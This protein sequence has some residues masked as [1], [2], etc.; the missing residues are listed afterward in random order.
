M[1]NEL[2]GV[3]LAQAD[4]ESHEG[5]APAAAETHSEVGHEAGG[6]GGESSLPPFLRFDPGVWIWTMVVFVALLVILKKM[7]WKPIIASLEDRDKTIKASL[8]QAA[9]IQEETKRMTEEQNRILAQARHEA[10]SMLQSSKQA[11]EDLRR[12]LEQAAQDEKA[13]IIASATHEIDAS[14]RAAMAD[15]KKTT[16]DLS[17]QIAE[18][19]IQSNM[20]D[21][22]QRALVDQLINE[23]SAAKT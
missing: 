2:S 4:A 11:A 10:N 21:A 17:I 18:K 7:A 16:A 15:L 22:K 13:R 8:E 12:K 19:L 23:V 14:K 9:R 3:L 1:N 20:D 6:H 5:A